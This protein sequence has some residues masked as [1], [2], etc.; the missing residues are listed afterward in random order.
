MPDPN[1]VAQLRQAI[2]DFIAERGRAKLDK[3]KDESERQK[4]QQNFAPEAWIANAAKRAKQ[5][6]IVTHALKY[7]HP[8]A[9]G[10]SLYVTG[11]E[12][13]GNTLIGTHSLQGQITPDVVGNAAALDVAKFL[14]IEVD[15]K[16]LWQ[17]AAERDP[18]LLAALPGEASQKHAWLEAFAAV[19]QPKGTVTSHK[20]AKQ[21]YWPLPDEG[22]HLLA[23]LFATS[24]AQRV[25]EILS[26]DRFSEESKNARAAHRDG[27]PYPRGYREWPNLLIQKHG[28]TK[29]QNISQLNT[30]RHGEV[31]LLPSLPP[32][33]QAR[34]VPYHVTNIFDRFGRLPEIRE[35]IEALGTFLAQAK[36]WNNA[37]IRSRRAHYVEAIIDT[38]LHY[39]V[40]IQQSPPGWSAASECEL[41]EAQ[42]LWLDPDRDDP[43]FQKR[44]AESDWPR[45]IAE[46]FGAWFNEQLRR[47][48]LPVGEAE[49]HAW[50]REFEASLTDTLKEMAP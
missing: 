29:P 18:D 21:L 31:W 2:A 19:V 42:R 7:A 16:P 12:Y 9:R 35:Q 34:N 1:I 23:P 10:T 5:I 25:W 15:G 13:A 45:K 6:Q 50:R 30:E 20:L 44:R 38:L 3:A 27:A 47:F 49:F 41:P 48:R 43:E 37:K 33:W 32:R 17:R 8:D 36:D 14:S 22:Y 24:L 26:K 39:A 40:A 4:I 46:S 28:S 11:N